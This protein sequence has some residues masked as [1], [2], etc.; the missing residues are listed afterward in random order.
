MLPELRAYE[1]DIRGG[2]VV[3]GGQPRWPCV[4]TVWFDSINEA[5]E[6]IRS[7]ALQLESYEYDDEDIRLT[8]VGQLTEVDE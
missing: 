4:I 7:L 5:L 1:F 2:R 8:W 6:T 3:A